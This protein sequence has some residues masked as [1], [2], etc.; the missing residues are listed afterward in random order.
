MNYKH[1]GYAILAYLSWGGLPLFWKLLDAIPAAYI[2]AHRILWASIAT[3]IFCMWLKRDYLLKYLRCAKTLFLFLIAGVLLSSN[4]WVYIYAV[5]SGQ[6]IEASLGYFINPLVS[7]V[8]GMIFLGEKLN[9]NQLVAFLLATA[10]VTYQTLNYGHFPWIAAILALSFGIYAL[11]KKKMNMEPMTALA[12]ETTSL[13]P[14][15]L[16]YIFLWEKTYSLQDFS[17]FFLLVMAGLVTALPLYWFGLAAAKI[18]LHAIGFLQY[19]APTMKLLL[20]IF[21]FNETFTKTHAV[22]FCLIWAGLA[23]YTGDKLHKLIFKQKKLKI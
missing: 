12:L 22:S 10:G 11:M 17:D 6:I 14:I 8:L 16:L 21:L 4:W 23:I 9:K 1:F 3:M 2:L 13:V 7:I 19:L 20:G 5:I 18:N 15:A